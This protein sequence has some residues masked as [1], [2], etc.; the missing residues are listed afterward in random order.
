MEVSPSVA[1]HRGRDQVLKTVLV[2]AQQF[3]DQLG[4]I[5]MLV[6]EGVHLGEVN[7][8]EFTITAFQVLARQRDYLKVR[9]LV[10]RVRAVRRAALF[11][12]IE[13]RGRAGNSSRA[14]DVALLANIEHR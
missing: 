11:Q 13:D 10:V 1:S 3:S 2:L 4:P 12:D 5:R 8:G 6:Q 9:P 7:E 14:V